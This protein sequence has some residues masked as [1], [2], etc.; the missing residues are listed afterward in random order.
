MPERKDPFRKVRKPCTGG[1]GRRVQTLEKIAAPLCR[2]CRRKRAR[3]QE[4]LAR[5]T[6]AAREAT[7]LAVVSN[8]AYRAELE[9]L[10]TWVREIH[11]PLVER[12][13]A[14]VDQWTQD[15]EDMA[16][17]LRPAKAA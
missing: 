9:A 16:D 3:K 5:L 6:D 4:D 7:R 11:R 8:H 2:N 10:L 15:A 14:D 17:R 1:C 12:M 13:I